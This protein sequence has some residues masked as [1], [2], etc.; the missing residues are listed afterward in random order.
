QKQPLDAAFLDLPER[1]LTEYRTNK[2]QRQASELGHIL[3]TAK[4]IREAVDRVVILGIGGS[5]LG[6][7]ALFEAC[8]HPYHNHQSRGERGERPRVFFEGNNVDNDAMHG[9]LD[10]LAHANPATTIDDRWAIVVI[11]KS[12]GTLETAVAF[13]LF[14]DALGK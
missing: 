8:C 13:R 7:R 3:G 2:G 14:H 12:G 1:I 11:T 4:R 5:Y 6:A 10:L 9:L